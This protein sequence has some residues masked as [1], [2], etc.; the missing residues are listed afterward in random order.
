MLI[1][2]I[3]CYSAVIL[4]GLDWS[5]VRRDIVKYTCTIAVWELSIGFTLGFGSLFWKTWRIYSIYRNKFPRKMVRFM[6]H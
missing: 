3:Y 5:I 4:F 6:Q 2:C 1:G